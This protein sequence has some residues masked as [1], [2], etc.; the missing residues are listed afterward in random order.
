[1]EEAVLKNVFGDKK[2]N[3][4]GENGRHGKEKE[5]VYS[6]DCW[7]DERFGILHSPSNNWDTKNISTGQIR[8]KGQY[9]KMI[10]A[11]EERDVSGVDPRS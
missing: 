3:S 5:I 6:D 9:K 2:T 7:N 10:D 4:S 11:T 8:K 1:M